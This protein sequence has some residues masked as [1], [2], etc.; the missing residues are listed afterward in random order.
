MLGGR[1]WAAGAGRP[2]LL[3]SVLNLTFLLLPCRV[4]SYRVLS[5][6][7]LSYRVLSYRAPARGERHGISSHLCLVGDLGRFKGRR[8]K[9]VVCRLPLLRWLRHVFHR[10]SITARA[11]LNVA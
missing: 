1:C 8:Q 4:L 11:R 2:E 3:D 10:V 5:Y 7:V 6:R 9:G